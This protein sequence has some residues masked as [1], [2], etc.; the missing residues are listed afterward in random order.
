MY[1]TL[2]MFF[3]SLFVVFLGVTQAGAATRIAVADLSYEE[4]VQTHFR[5]LSVDYRHTRT[6]GRWDQNEERDLVYDEQEG[7]HLFIDRGAL[8]QW[9]ADIKGELLRAGYQV[10]QARPFSM[11]EQAKLFDVIGR[12]KQGEYKGADYVLFGTVSSVAFRE[13]SSPVAGTA[14]TFSE[15]LSLELVVEFSLIHTKSHAVVAAFSAMGEGSD[16]RLRE[17][18]AARVYPSRGKAIMEAAKGLALDVVRQMPAQTSGNTP[19]VP[20]PGGGGAMPPAQEE[21]TIYR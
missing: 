9:T 12:I 7:S 11:K 5:A 17:S 6:G 21:V 16:V 20:I 3:F 10:V 14:R 8:H 18:A 2:M 1:R 15:S 19:E 4:R 13:E